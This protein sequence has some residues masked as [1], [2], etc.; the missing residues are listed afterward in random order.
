MHAVPTKTLPSDVMYI[1]S[2]IILLS[3]DGVL[4][5]IFLRYW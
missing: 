3:P 2:Y 5:Y 4:G 1:I